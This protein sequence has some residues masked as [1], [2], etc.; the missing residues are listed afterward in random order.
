MAKRSRVAKSTKAAKL[1]VPAWFARRAAI[2]LGLLVLRVLIQQ[3]ILDVKH[4]HEL[5][6]VRR[7]LR[8]CSA[9]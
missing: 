3:L 7:L 8:R 2:V 4:A 5:E 1:E 6:P 9:N